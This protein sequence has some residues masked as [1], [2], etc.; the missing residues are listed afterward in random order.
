MYSQGGVGGGHYIAYVLHNGVWNVANDTIITEG[1]EFDPVRRS[2]A[3]SCYMLFYARCAR[4]VD[5]E[6]R[7]P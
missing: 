3:T 6:I 7:T 2:V 5:V 4:R 1:L